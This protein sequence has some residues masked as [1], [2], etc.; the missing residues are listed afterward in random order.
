M[1]L[2]ALACCSRVH[3]IAL[4]GVIFVSGVPVT[5]KRL[6]AAGGPIP[7]RAPAQAEPGPEQVQPGNINPATA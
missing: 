6:V 2:L 7:G 5:V 4:P 3:I 1:W